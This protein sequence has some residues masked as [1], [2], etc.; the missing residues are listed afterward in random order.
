MKHCERTIMKDKLRIWN[1]RRIERR[2]LKYQFRSTMDGFQYKG[3]HSQFEDSWEPLTRAL[4]KAF[5]NYTLS[6]VNI[7]AHYGYYAC[8]AAQQGMKVTA[9]E[10]IDANYQMLR[11]NIDT[12]NFLY[13]CRLVHAAVGDRSHLAKIYGAFSGA[14]LI[15]EMTKKS[16]SM[17]QITQVFELSD[18]RLSSEPTLF[19][20][21]VEGYE[22]NVLEG[23]RNHL[24]DK[25][26]NIWIV[27]TTSKNSEE[28]ST[29]MLK[30]GYSLLHIGHKKLSA[31]TKQD[32]KKG[33]LDGNFLCID[34]DQ[35]QNSEL[36]EAFS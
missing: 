24:A 9:F 35:K 2:R 27:E 30:H 13:D 18:F 31:V 4:V 19:L 36:V 25:S 33:G 14:S 5:S 23:A 1:S 26:K 28:F 34:L 7:G 21:D 29:K 32:I 12:N 16:N 10:P 8:L 11:D 3:I 17:Y 6:F 20:I 15:P 22:L